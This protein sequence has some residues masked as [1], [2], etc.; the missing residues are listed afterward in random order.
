LATVT[1]VQFGGVVSPSFTVLS[2]TQ[3]VAAVPT[4]GASGTV[5]VTN[6]GG[7]ASLGG[8]TFTATIPQVSTFAG[9]AAPAGFA[10]GTGGAAR[11]NEPL[12]IAFHSSGDMFVADLN[13]HRIRRIT[14]LGVV[15]TLAGSGVAGFAD[16]TGAAAQFNR[17]SGLTIDGSGN[18]IVADYAGHRIRVVTPGGAVTTLAGSGVAGFADA[19]G[20][21]AQFNNP[22]AVVLVGGFVYVADQGGFRIRRITYP[23]GVVT[24][25]AG[26]G[27][28]GFVNGTGVAAQFGLTEGLAADGAGNIYVTDYSNHSIRKITPGGVVT[29]LA[30]S[31]AAGFADGLGAAALF[32]GPRGIAV[33]AVGNLYVTDA[34]NARMRLVSP[35]GNVTTFAGSGVAGALDGILAAGQ[36]STLI[37]HLA[38]NSSGILFVAD[39]G[40]NAIRR[41]TTPSIVTAFTPTSAGPGDVVTITGINFTGATQVQFGGVNAASYTV[42]DAN[43]ITATPAAGGATGSVS[44]TAPLG[45]S[46]LAGFTFLPNVFYS[47]GADPGIRT[48]WNSLPGGGG[49]NPTPA[50]FMNKSGD[51][52]ILQTSLTLFTPFTIGNGVTFT[53]SAGAVLS[54]NANLAIAAGGTHTVPAGTSV[55]ING[56]STLT[57][58]GTLNVSGIL[59]LV[60]NAG[61]SGTSPNFLGTANL[62]YNGSGNLNIGSE[63]SALMPAGTNIAIAKNPGTSLTMTGNR[64]LNGGLGYA[65]GDLVMAGNTLTL[66]GGIAFGAGTQIQGGAGASIVV[67]GAGAITGTPVFIAPQTLGGGLTMNR[68]GAT[69]AL[70]SSLTATPLTIS[71]GTLNTGAF[72]HT[73]SA[74]NISASGSLAVAAGGSATALANY[75]VGGNITID[76]TFDAGTTVASGT[77]SIVIN[78][79]GTFTSAHPAGL[80]GALTNTGG[81]SYAGT[82]RIQGA[83]V[84]NSLGLTLNNLIIDR[85][86]P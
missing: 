35:T 86:T 78:P 1:Q 42:V 48:N 45:T 41:V 43:T 77:G 67:G 13:N 46:S 30:G 11:L 17:P 6:P 51:T 7:A 68:G 18:A 38:L 79:V 83:T 37:E 84:G 22:V 53:H 8:F 3:I 61:Y 81:I 31:G 40:N 33:D 64:T 36:F 82:V 50:Q 19:T 55:S 29:T 15:T 72:A 74:L 9:N 63:W 56:P 57:N 2:N 14:P 44:V 16:G 66:N 26:S 54:L 62:V 12:G 69:L 32:N 25:F 71:G 4:G 85:A 10:D 34:N 24:T 58:N 21:A 76:G 60:N 59:A 27:T 28:S 20:V 52:Y 65:V 39:R 75:T 80:V 49:V 70:G 73:F 5:Q 23:G 47:Q